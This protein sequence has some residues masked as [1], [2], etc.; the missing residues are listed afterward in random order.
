MKRVI[1]IDSR[2]CADN[3][4]ARM[5]G[6]RLVAGAV[7][8]LACTAFISAQAQSI[9][10]PPTSA[11]TSKKS[12]DASDSELEAI[13]V[14]GIKAAIQSAI[15]VKRESGSIVEAVSAEDIG[16]LPDTSI[17]ESISRL[18]GLTS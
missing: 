13:V 11:T 4:L 3:S 9:G 14:T 1:N 2:S 12:T 8:L 16:K 18:P 6:S 15:Q 7:L 10:A 5:V 17:A